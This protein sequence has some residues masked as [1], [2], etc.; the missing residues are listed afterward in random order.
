MRKAILIAWS[1]LIVP[2]SVAAQN[3]DE[4][5]L[6]T[7]NYAPLNFER[8]GVAQGI[9]VDIMVE[10]LKRVG[11]TKT[12]A[13]IE[14]QPWARGYKAATE[15]KNTAL[16]AMTRTEARE[17]S[18]KWVGPLIPSNIVL[19]AKKNRAI[20]VNSMDDVKRYV[21]HH[22]QI[23]V[24]R[25]DIGEQMLVELGVD[26]KR[27]HRVAQPENAV[28]ML[29]KDR[30]SMWAYGRI[31][32]YWYLKELGYDPSDY[33]EVYVLKQSDQ[34]FA[35]HKDTHDEIVAQ[36]QGALDQLKAS[37]EFQNILNKYLQ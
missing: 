5:V 6:I 9:S 8:N 1:F 19:V 20:T 7:E 33:E 2:A 21:A 11:S 31:V 35:F 15:V 3:V 29:H 28:H 25:D 22:E 18:F 32:A 14:V 16:F 34:Y 10:M 13:D 27:I 23:G 4:L 30:I 37:D 26:D 24:V 12:R 17:K 36:L